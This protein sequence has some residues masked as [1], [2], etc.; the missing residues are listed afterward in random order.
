MKWRDLDKMIDTFM[1]MDK[2]PNN[3]PNLFN[4]KHIRECVSHVNYQYSTKTLNN[5]NSIDNF[6]TPSISVFINVYI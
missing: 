6:E 5:L 3:T 1:I 2:Y 4:Y